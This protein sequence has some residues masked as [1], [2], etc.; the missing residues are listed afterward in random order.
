MKSIYWVEPT[1]HAFTRVED[2]IKQARIEQSKGEV[3]IVTLQLLNQNDAR[4]LRA[5]NI[6]L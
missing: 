2:A 5:V 1:L 3:S 4:A 6:E